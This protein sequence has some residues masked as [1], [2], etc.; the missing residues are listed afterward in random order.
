MQIKVLYMNSINLINFFSSFWGLCIVELNN[1][2]KNF[3]I[4]I[5][6]VVSF[7]FKGIRE[8]PTPSVLEC[9]DQSE[10][11]CKII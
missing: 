5:W 10:L 7:Y 8:T 3:T 1:N 6:K 9:E 4:T 2:N 11:K